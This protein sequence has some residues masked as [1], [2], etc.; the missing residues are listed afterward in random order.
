MKEL[1]SQLLHPLIFSMGVMLKKQEDAPHPP[2][3]KSASKH[4][5]KVLIKYK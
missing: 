3:Y 1:N 2:K 5:L 4:L